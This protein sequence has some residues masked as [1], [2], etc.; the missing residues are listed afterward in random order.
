[1]VCMFLIYLIYV[2]HN[3]LVTYNIS[4]ENGNGGIFGISNKEGRWLPEV[5]K[6]TGATYLLV[7]YQIWREVKPPF[8]DKDHTSFHGVKLFW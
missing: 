4:R 2:Y 1:M 8:F 5:R 6:N 3:Q 7:L